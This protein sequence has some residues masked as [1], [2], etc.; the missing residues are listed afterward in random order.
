[1]TNS[2]PLALVTGASSG[3]GLEFAELLAAES[4]D[5][6]LVARRIDR[7]RD[8]AVRLTSR[9]G[10]SVEPISAD[11]ADPQATAEIS[12]HLNGRVPDILV[13]NAGFGFRGAAVQLPVERQ[14][15]MI[16]VNIT[17]LAG[18]VLRIAPGMI[19]RGSGRII[20]VGSAAGFQP[21]PF[22][23]AYFA[24]KSFVLS[25]S[26]ALSEELRGTG[27]TVTCLAPGPVATEFSDLAGMGATMHFRMGAMTAEKVARQGLAGARRGQ[28]LVV[29]GWR[30]RLGLIAVRFAPRGLVL[31]I[32]RWMQ[33]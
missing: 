25:Y 16:Q 14:A 15:A 29:P 20:N 3:I 1:M 18:L 26:E 2:K 13:N 11:L 9:Y 19:A 8:I 33:K 5:L 23:A 24:T 28:R 21:G 27:V 12:S 17:A 4:H 10:V 32:V 30:N 22:M 6:V 31:K 7:L